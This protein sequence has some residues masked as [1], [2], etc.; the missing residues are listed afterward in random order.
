MVLECRA[1]EH[2]MNTVCVESMMGS[3]G[4]L[5]KVAL[6]LWTSVCPCPG[7]VRVGVRARLDR[8]ILRV[9]EAGMFPITSPRP[10]LIRRIV[11]GSTTCPEYLA[12]EANI[13]QRNGNIEPWC[14][15]G[16]YGGIYSVSAS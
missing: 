7:T 11:V 8:Q 13:G 3:R 9:T 16:L 10:N 4:M 1:T 15:H 2:K 5:R 12:I 14:F 6:G